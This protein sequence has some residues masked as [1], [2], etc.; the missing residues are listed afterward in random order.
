MARKCWVVFTSE[1]VR[2][3]GCS[4]VGVRVGTE[5]N[6]VVVVVKNSYYDLQE[7][8]IPETITDVHP[9]ISSK[10]FFWGELALKT[11]TIVSKRIEL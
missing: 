7:W 9:H 1:S 3:C 5:A 11:K 8:N 10:L 2:V 4:C 6:F